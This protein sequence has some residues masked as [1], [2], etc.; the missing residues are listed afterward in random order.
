MVKLAL[1]GRRIS[2]SKFSELD[3]LKQPLKLVFLSRLLDWMMLRHLYQPKLFYDSY[4]NIES[5]YTDYEN[6]PCSVQVEKWIRGSHILLNLM[7]S[8]SLESISLC[9]CVCFIFL[10]YLYMTKVIITWTAGSERSLETSLNYS[11]FAVNS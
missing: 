10:F 3:C 1:G 7:S 5:T 11:N 9:V 8:A 2:I 4:S 6:Y